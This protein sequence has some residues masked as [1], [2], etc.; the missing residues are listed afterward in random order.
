MI[1][2]NNTVPNWLKINDENLNDLLDYLCAD[3]K[4]KTTDPFYAVTKE[5]LRSRVSSMIHE[6]ASDMNARKEEDELTFRIRMTGTW[7]LCCPEPSEERIQVFFIMLNCLSRIVPEDLSQ[8]LFSLSVRAVCSGEVASLGFSWNDLVNVQKEVLGHKIVN[9]ALLKNA[10]KRDLWYEGKGSLHVTSEDISIIPMARKSFISA[11]SKMTESMKILDSRLCVFTEKG[12]RLKQSDDSNV[13]AIEMFTTTFRKEQRRM[14]SEPVRKKGYSVGDEVMVRVKANAGNSLTLET[15][16]PNYETIVGKLNLSDGLFYYN[17]ADFAHALQTGD[18]FRAVVTENR[19]VMA[20]SVHDIFLEKLLEQVEQE[21][22]Y[23]AKYFYNNAKNG[24]V[25]LTETGVPVYVEDSGLYTIGDRAFITIDQI[26]GNGYIKGSIR[27]EQDGIEDAE[28][29]DSKDWFIK[30]CIREDY[31]VPELNV[32]ETISADFVRIFE[33]ALYD[34]QKGLSIASDIYKI[35]CFCQMLAELTEDERELDFLNLKADY[36]EQLVLFTRGRYTEMKQLVPSS[37][38]AEIPSVVR[39][40][41]LVN[42]LMQIGKDGDSELLSNLTLSDDPLIAK[43]AMIM[44]SYNRIKGIV[45]ESSLNDLKVEIIRE[46]SLD[47]EIQASLDDNDEEFIGVED[48]VKEFKTSFIYPAEKGVRTIPN[49]KKQSK[50]VFR[51]VCAFLNS[52]VG[53]TLYLGVSDAGY[54][55]GLDSDLN[56]CENSLDRYIRLIQDEAKL[57][58][59]KSILDFLDFDIMFD[60][61]VVAVKVRPF[62]DGVVCMDGTPY[63]RRYGESEP[64]RED[65]RARVIATKIASGLKLGTKV[66]ILEQAISSKRR[67]ILRRFSSSEKTADRRVEPFKLVQNKKYVWC[68][69]LE[70]HCCKQ[71]GLSKMGSAEI[72]QDQW[73]HESEHKEK[74]TDIFNWSGEKPVHILLEMDLTAK[75]IIIEEF[76]LSE[77]LLQK[78]DREGYKWHLETDILSLIAPGRFC[79]GLAN[80]VTILQGDELKAY[81]RDFVKTNFAGCP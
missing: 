45:P 24:S 19:G 35:L 17:G 78:A 4:R 67:V 34:Y 75:N 40:V 1:H 66:G 13:S 9:G 54:V 43:T 56:L 2:E 16:D 44:Q 5:L 8:K 7:L 58:F 23:A 51:A 49:L 25:W 42:I 48:K 69:D 59:D 41:N 60:G 3:A 10:P 21:R 50:V 31:D 53:G 46:L 52:K 64:M 22:Y 30:D 27:D 61:R 81:I 11:K 71:F 47:G 76:P 72:L 38:I 29:D 36:L 15:A 65:E 6:I 18:C 28:L 62:D 73:T 37:N 70:D 68:Y 14:A 20:F 32:I 33:R 12:E 74:Q 77:K 79:I 57:V 80:H 39:S 26:T 63:I 55:V